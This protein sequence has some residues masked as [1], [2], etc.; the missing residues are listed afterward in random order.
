M[1]GRLPP[2]AAMK[3]NGAD[4]S[5]RERDSAPGA[6][7]HRLD[8]VRDILFGEALRVVEARLAA[9]EDRLTE[10]LAEQAATHQADQAR[11]EA[12]TGAR[13]DDLTRRMEVVER[14]KSDRRELARQL[15]DLAKGLEDGAAAD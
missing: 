5:T 13:I 12:A 6:S 7:Q 9:L 3:S 15:R 14:D 8:Q 2:P 4:P 1:S 11:S 10:Q